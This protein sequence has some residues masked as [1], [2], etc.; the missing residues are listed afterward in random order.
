MC[1]VKQEEELKQSSSWSKFKQW[2]VNDFL[3]GTIT[4]RFRIDNDPWLGIWRCYSSANY[5]FVGFSC[6]KGRH[7][8]CFLLKLRKGL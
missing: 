8:S 5:V 4:D 3:Y 1:I 6:L 2:D 7:Y